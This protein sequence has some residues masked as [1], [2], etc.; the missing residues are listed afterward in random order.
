MDSDSGDE[1]E[2]QPRDEKSGLLGQKYEDDEFLD[3]LRDQERVKTTDIAETV[4]CTARTARLRLEKLADRGEVAR[5]D[6]GSVLVW[7]LRDEESDQ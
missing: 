6:Y 3:V 7:R 5:E 1:R 4:G 2:D